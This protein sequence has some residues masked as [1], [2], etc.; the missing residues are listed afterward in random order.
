MKRSRPSLLS[1]RAPRSSRDLSRPSHAERCH[2]AS[3]SEGQQPGRHG[4]PGRP[5]CCPR[6]RGERRAS[7]V[8]V[9]FAGPALD[10]VLRPKSCCSRSRSWAWSC[11]SSCLS[12]ASRATA[13][14]SMASGNR[15]PVARARTPGRVVGRRDK[16]PRGS[17]EPSK[18]LRHGRGV[19]RPAQRH[20]GAVRAV[21][22]RRASG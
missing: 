10:S 6:E 12:R 11:A 16:V 2:H 19:S 17:G 14:S 22:L 5:G 8:S 4:G 21:V 20:L 1:L 3:P 9:V 15:R 13:R 18:C 7:A